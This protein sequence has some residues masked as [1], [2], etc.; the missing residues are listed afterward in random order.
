MVS[1][2]CTW[3]CCKVLPVWASQ[4]RIELSVE[5]EMTRVPSCEMATEL[6]EL[7]CPLSSCKAPPVWASQMRMELSSEPE[8]TRVPPCEM[9]TE[10]TELKCPSIVR[11]HAS[12]SFLIVLTTR[13]PSPSSD[14]YIL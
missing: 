14:T 10:L 7:E 4:M 1:H 3:N 11:K 12:H 9:A 5:P 2:R 6:T 8:M 13:G